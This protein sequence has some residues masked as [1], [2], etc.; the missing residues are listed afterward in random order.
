[1]KSDATAE[2]TSRL[3]VWRKAIN[4]LSDL[5]SILAR[6]LRRIC[7]KKRD[8]VDDRISSFVAF[9][10][11]LSSCVLGVRST[12]SIQRLH[13]ASRITY[14][15]LPLSLSPSLL[16]YC[17]DLRSNRNTIVHVTQKQLPNIAPIHRGAVL[18]KAFSPLV[19]RA[20]PLPG[21]INW[22]RR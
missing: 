15:S 22:R 20:L 4:F 7:T 13:Q 16:F 2:Q 18:L 10:L 3:Y 9:A 6:C 19:P 21:E 8:C 12:C 5:L 17:F 1:M 14:S 11:S